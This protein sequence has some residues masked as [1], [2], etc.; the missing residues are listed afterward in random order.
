MTVIISNSK[1]TW[2]TIISIVDDKGKMFEKIEY[3]K[4]KW[5]HTTE[6]YVNYTIGRFTSWVALG[7]LEDDGIS[8]DVNLHFKNMAGNTIVI[9]SEEYP[10]DIEELQSLSNF[11]EEYEIPS[12]FYFERKLN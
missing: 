10:K 4:C 11:D 1:D 2:H 8:S 5:Q 6:W 3:P 9:S 7:L 12:T